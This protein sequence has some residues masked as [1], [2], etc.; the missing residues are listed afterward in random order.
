MSTADD[1]LRYVETH[2]W[3]GARLQDD[4]HLLELNPVHG[5]LEAGFMLWQRL[6]DGRLWPLASGHVRDGR[7]YGGEN[8]PLEFDDDTLALIGKLLEHGR[9]PS[10]Q[11]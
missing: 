2:R 4:R 8:E 11:A 3:I 7:F 9:A 6:A 10:E 5:K 1:L